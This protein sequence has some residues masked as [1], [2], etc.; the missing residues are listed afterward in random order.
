MIRKFIEGN[1]HFSDILLECHESMEVFCKTFFPER[2]ELPFC[3]LHRSI[4]NLLDGEEQRVAIIAPRGIG[5]TSM[6]IAY[7]A[8][9]ILFQDRGYIVFVS[10]SASQAIEKTEELKHELLSNEVVKKIFGPIKSDKSEDEFSKMAW[11]TQTGVRVLPRGGLQQIRGLLYQSKRPDLIIFDDFEDSESVMSEEQRAKKKKWFYSDALRAI[12]RSMTPKKTDRFYRL[13]FDGT[14]LHEDSLLNNIQD[15]PLWTS[16]RLSLI[17]EEGHSLWP[18]QV[19]DEEIEREM[20]AARETGTLE[21]FYMELANEI[22][23]GELAVFPSKYFQYYEESEANLNENPDIQTVILVDP[24]KTQNPKSA[25]SAIVGVGIDVVTHAIYV[26]DIVN[27]KFTPDELYDHIFAMAKDL[28][29]WNIG[30]E[31]N[32][33]NNFITYPMKNEMAARNLPYDL[34]DLKPRDKK[35]N[36]VKQLVPLYRRGF[37]YHNK[38]CASILEQQLMSFPRSKKWDVMDAFAYIV[39]MLDEGDR[40]FLPTGSV[41][42]EY[43]TLDKMDP[44]PETWR[45]V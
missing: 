17:D 8:R 24:A 12:D 31:V 44:L 10:N 36:R 23:P 1:P 13:V 15:D 22:V 21:V 2:F 7:M 27:G 16:T 3:D 29:V 18:D 19:T 25:D 39:P 20:Q 45:T 34:I 33:L 28:K 35:E 41:E 30:I 9:T 37:V 32:S 6:M 40:Y 26:R 42:D 5:K 43:A 11:V 4:F 14:I 38:R